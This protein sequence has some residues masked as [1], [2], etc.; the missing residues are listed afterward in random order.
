M[1]LP[2]GTGLTELKAFWLLLYRERKKIIMPE[3]RSLEQET[4]VHL[5]VFRSRVFLETPVL[6][7]SGCW[8]SE[9][10]C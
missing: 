4:L 9:T 8:H 5:F 1:S 6:K 2:L 7:S 3:T 10:S